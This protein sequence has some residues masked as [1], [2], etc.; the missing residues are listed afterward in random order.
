[1][2]IW[3][4][5]Q[6]NVHQSTMSID[7]FLHPCLIIRIMMKLSWEFIKE[8]VGH[9]YQF[10]GRT[11]QFIKVV[12]FILPVSAVSN[13]TIFPL[14]QST[15]LIIGVGAIF[16]LLMVG[17]FLAWRRVSVERDELQLELKE[18]RDTIPSYSI[19]IDESGIKKFSVSKFIEKVEEDI[20]TLK[21]N[22]D[23]RREARRRANSPSPPN[24]SSN[25]GNP[26]ADII[27]GAN[28]RLAQA[29]QPIQAIFDRLDNLPQITSLN[30]RE[31]PKGK[32]E[33]LESNLKKLKEY[34]ENLS[35][36]YI[37]P[38]YMNH[39][40]FDENIEISMETDPKVELQLKDEEEIKADIPWV[41]TPRSNSFLDFGD[42]MRYIPRTNYV[43]NI[44]RG[45]SGNQAWSDIKQLNVQKY[46]IAVF[47][48]HLLVS[49]T[50]RKLSL[51][52]HISSKNLNAPQ[53]TK[54]SCGLTGA[55]V[56]QIDR[57]NVS[58]EVESDQS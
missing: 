48:P 43:P 13:H 31:T 5:N 20:K 30:H 35:K 24:S 8:I 21:L 10:G 53:I 44:T 28:N 40:R 23:E 14:S 55:R 41:E 57:D 36:T 37:V 56:E 15:R 34:E 4:T 38:I 32:L 12:A 46:P 51:D 7:H 58:E 47:N 11:L 45:A 9:A 17:A 22:I 3:G 16:I 27:N 25:S 54:K 26:W 1:M 33:R 49:T 6:L 29:M 50:S 18:T 19:S 42:T 52:I 2:F 39:T